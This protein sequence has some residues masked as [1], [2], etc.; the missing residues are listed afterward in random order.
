MAVNIDFVREPLAQHVSISGEFPG[1]GELGLGAGDTLEMYVVEG[2]MYMRL[3]GSWVQ[4]PASKGTLD[5]DQ[6][7]FLAAKDVLDGL[8]VAEYEGKAEYNGVETEHYAF[9]EGSFAPEDLPKGMEIEE[10]SGNVYVAVDGSY[11]VHMDVTMSGSD[12]ELPTGKQGELL[13]NGTM[14]IG[15]DLFDINQPITIQLPNE[16]LSSGA[17]PED[18]PVPD[19]AQELQVVAFMGMITFRS[20]RSPQEIADFYRA[21]MPNNGWT[22]VS[23]D[24]TGG[25][26]T[27][28]YSK[29]DRKASLLITT[30]SDTGRTSVLVT[31]EGGE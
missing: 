1:M 15:V 19:D 18:I 6:M 10:A 24:Q 16:A 20:P 17:P 26:Q 11:V 7:A 3:F 25:T 5:P 9:D 14:N 2:I 27:L 21:E 30:D 13:R 23:V 22:E 28:E 31:T 8:K 4:A 12:L 29:G